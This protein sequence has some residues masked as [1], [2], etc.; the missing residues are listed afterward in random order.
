MAKRSPC[1]NCERKDLSKEDCAITCKPKL[2]YLEYTN[3]GIIITEE[4]KQ[5][6]ES[7]NISTIRPE[8][9]EMPDYNEL[10]DIG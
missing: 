5:Y 9:L 2:A 4:Y 1:F 8:V 10:E 7:F 3:N 6:E